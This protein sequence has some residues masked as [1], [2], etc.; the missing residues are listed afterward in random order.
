M[1]PLTSDDR[2]EF[3]YF[4]TCAALDAMLAVNCI[5]FA[6]FSGY[7]LYGAF[8]GA[9]CTTLA[10][11]GDNCIRT[12]CFAVACGTTLVYNV[13]HNFFAEIFQG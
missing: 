3:A 1:Y 4:G 5:W 11:F 9:K 8:S 7:A 2:A 13:C 12:Q 6:F 10:F